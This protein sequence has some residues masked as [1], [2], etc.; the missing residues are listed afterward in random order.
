MTPA[1][2]TAEEQSLHNYA[3]VSLLHAHAGRE[4]RG[5]ITRI[6]GYDRCDTLSSLSMNRGQACAHVADSFPCFHNGMAAGGLESEQIS[7]EFF[8]SAG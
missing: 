4:K 6:C 3:K 7:N 2:N 5:V 8:E 1:H